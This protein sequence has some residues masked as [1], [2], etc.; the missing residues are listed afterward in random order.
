L[1]IPWCAAAHSQ[2]DIP[3]GFSNSKHLSQKKKRLS[4]DFAEIYNI[5]KPVYSEHE[6]ESHRKRGFLLK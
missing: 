6:C 1:I 5:V 3:L 2:F 4:A